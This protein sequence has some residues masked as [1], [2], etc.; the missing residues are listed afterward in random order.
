[1]DKSLLPT[2]IGRYRLD[3]LVVTNDDVT[4]WAATD[5][6]RGTSVQLSIFERGSTVL[7]QGKSESGMFVAIDNSS[8]PARLELAEDDDAPAPVYAP[9]PRE[10][11]RRRAW[12]WAVAGL[13]C[14]L[15]AL[16]GWYAIANRAQPISETTITSSP[17]PPSTAAATAV[18]TATPTPTPP[19]PANPKPT[20]TPV[21]ATPQPV[22]APRR[23]APPPQRAKPFLP[24]PK[25]IKPRPPAPAPSF[26]PI[27]I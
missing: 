9:E 24:A 21:I 20:A 10:E 14:A 18:V 11:E 5:L 4:I 16:G 1:V 3:R 27:T 12:P 15:A 6:A 23:E 7:Q 22:A 19:P 13:A 8:R 26:D 25:P 17:L 2:F